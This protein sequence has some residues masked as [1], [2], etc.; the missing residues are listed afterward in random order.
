MKQFLQV[1]NVPELKEFRKNLRNNATSQEQLLWNKLRNSGLNGCKFRRQHSVGDF[2][3]DFYCA[4]HKLAIELDGNH[5]LA[6]EHKLNDEARTAFLNEMNIRVLR[7]S[8][9]EIETNIDG[10]L[11]AIIDNIQR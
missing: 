10:V 6:E 8:N 3:L 4:E 1:H 7:F 11:N 5:H 9:K 2:I